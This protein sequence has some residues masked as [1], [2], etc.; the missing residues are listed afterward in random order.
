MEEHMLQQALVEATFKFPMGTEFIS[1]VGSHDKVNSAPW[2]DPSDNIIKV[3][4]TN[5]SP[6]STRNIY[7]KICGVYQ[8]AK[9]KEPVVKND[10][11]IY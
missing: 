3:H 11:Q 5:G 7:E 10:Y 8:W 9:I 2:I 6:R 1:T 4:G